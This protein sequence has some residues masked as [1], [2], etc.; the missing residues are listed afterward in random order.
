M[1]FCL[2]SKDL[3]EMMENEVVLDIAEKHGKTAAQVMLRY[4]IQRDIVVIPKSTNLERLAENIQV[5][6]YYSRKNVSHLFKPFD[7]LE[8]FSI[9]NWTPMIWNT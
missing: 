4:L 3:P 8:R 6:S 9:L 7:F 5:Y 2:Y 1:S